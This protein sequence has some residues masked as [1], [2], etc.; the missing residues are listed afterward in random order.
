MNPLEFI[1]Q[2]RRSDDATKKRWLIILSALAMLVVLVFWSKYFAASL[3]RPGEQPTEDQGFSF[4][5][6]MGTGLK[7][8]GGRA[9][10]LLRGAGGWLSRSN[11]YVIQPSN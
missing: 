4:W 11:N 1:K 6:T 5:E 8:V 7:V 10:S 2:L 3:V 9:A